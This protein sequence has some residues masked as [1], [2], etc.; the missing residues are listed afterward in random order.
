MTSESSAA[1][2]NKEEFTGSPSLKS[3]LVKSSM[4]STSVDPNE[5][6]KAVDMLIKGI[7]HNSKGEHVWDLHT[8]CF[9]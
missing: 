8:V 5:L 6:H 9:T 2:A 4:E 7:H 3:I 1:I